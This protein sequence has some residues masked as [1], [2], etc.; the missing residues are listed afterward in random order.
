MAVKGVFATDA[1]VAATR[2]QDF[3]S[4]LIQVH[5]TG[6]AQM[7]ALSAGLQRYAAKD[8]TITWFERSHDTGRVLVTNNAGT[9]TSL[10]VSAAHATTM[11]PNQIYLAET[12]GEYILVSSVSGTTITVQRGVG[13]VAA[14]ALDGSGTA[15][16][17]QLIANAHEEGSARPAAIAHLGAPVYNFTQIF[18]NSWDHTG[19]AAAVGWHTG[20]QIAQNKA[21]AGNYHAEAIERQLMWGIR[22]YGV[23]NNQP[24]RTFNGLKAMITTNIANQVTNGNDTNWDDINDWLQAIY[25]KN[26]KGKANERV[27]FCGNTVIKVLNSIAR[28]E[29]TMQLDPGEAE[30]GLAITKWITPFGRA[31][32]IS[33]PLFNESPH[34]TK[35]LVAWHP[36]A[37]KIRWLRATHTDA[38]DRDGTR[39]GVDGDYGVITSELSFEYNAEQ[40]AGYFS[41]IDTAASV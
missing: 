4:G 7:L 17:L 11:L 35:D 25:A 23:Q 22:A 3:Q 39:A 26:I 33:H 5:P 27:F 2:M 13:P 41:G 40:T 19:T 20:D 1:G 28:I 18:R 15:K 8:T 29:G 9:G 21:D 38:Y 34:F 30:F 10:T 24:W 6:N 31:A 36:A 32:L 37:A 16:G 12:T 14:Q